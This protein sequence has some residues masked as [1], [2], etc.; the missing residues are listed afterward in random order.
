MWPASE[1]WRYEGTV[2]MKV[3]C[4]ENEEYVKKIE[5]ICIE[6]MCGYEEGQWA[7]RRKWRRKWWYS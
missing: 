1:V 2:L 3:P 5:E 4:E 7:M 6:E